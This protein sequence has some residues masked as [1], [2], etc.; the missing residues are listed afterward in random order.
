MLL[1][2]KYLFIFRYKIPRKKKVL[3]PSRTIIEPVTG[4]GDS[5]LISPEKD[6]NPQEIFKAFYDYNIWIL[7]NEY[8]NNSKIGWTT[9]SN[10]PIQEQSKLAFDRLKH[11]LKLKDDGN[12]QFVESCIL[13]TVRQIVFD[14]FD[15]EFAFQLAKVALTNPQFLITQDINVAWNVPKDF[16][17]ELKK[18]APKKPKKEKAKK[19]KTKKDKKEKKKSNSDK[20][21]SKKSSKKS[22][23][24]TSKKSKKSDKEGKKPKMTKEEKEEYEKKLK[25][26]KQL[27]EELRIQY[28]NTMFMFPLNDAVNIEFLVKLFPNFKPKKTKGKGEKEKGSKS[29]K[30]SKKTDSSKK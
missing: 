18:P 29:S 9:L 6:P 17:Q 16:K 2:N 21:S 5:V 27:E 22:E 7:K 26:Q 20:K 1:I 11:P 30:S 19:E 28:E 3:C 10:N 4:S 25:E 15:S 13:M 24:K 14:Y 23:K 12:L 8:M